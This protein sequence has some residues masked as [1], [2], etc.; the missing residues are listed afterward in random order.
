M[1]AL[2]MEPGDVVVTNHPGFGGSH[3]PDITLISPVHDE[4]GRRIGFVA[5]RAHHAEIGG[6][7]PGSCRPTPGTWP[8]KAW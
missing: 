6:K 3:L 8:K 2:P 4:A 1:A 5:N 7:R